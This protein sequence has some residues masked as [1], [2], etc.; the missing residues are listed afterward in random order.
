[1]RAIK[2]IRP[3]YAANAQ[4]RERF[5]REAEYLDQLRHPNI[6]R[7]DT[8][9]DEEGMLFMVMERLEGCAVD[10]FVGAPS[11]AM[12]CRIVYEAA[13]GLQKA[14]QAQ[15][16]HRDVKP[17][18]LVVTRDGGLRVLDFG[19]ARGTGS[20][21]LTLGPTTGGAY[22]PGTPAYYAPE[23]AAGKVATPQSDLYSL[24]VTLY[25]VLTG[26][27]PYEPEPGAEDS[28]VFSFMM[29]SHLQTPMPDV[30]R[31]RPEVPEGVQA[32]LQWATRKL[33]AER[34][35]DAQV[36]AERLK[37]FC[38][39]SVPLRLP[40]S[41]HP[42][43]WEPGMGAT[44]QTEP[45]VAFVSGVGATAMSLERMTAQE[46]APAPLAPVD[47]G[48]GLRLGLGLGLVG[49]LGAGV[50]AL[51]PEPPP[52]VAPSQLVATP[53]QHAP[54]ERPKPAPPE[55]P[56]PPAPPVVVVAQPEPKPKPEP[57]PEPK[58]DPKPEPE[59]VAEILRGFAF[60]PKR[61]GKAL[62]TEAS[63]VLPKVSLRVAGLDPVPLPSRTGE[64]SLGKV[65]VFTLKARYVHQAAGVHLELFS[66]PTGYVFLDKH[67]VGN[68]QAGY[69]L[70]LW[71]G[72][73]TQQVEL[74]EGMD[75]SVV[76]V[77]LS[78]VGR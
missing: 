36:F 7:V 55:P 43:R 71:V 70:N 74:H 27:L 59:P 44:R 24:G 9:G 3:E 12:A 78:L 50:V 61:P 46:E 30:R 26:R 21:Q 32:L 22:Q 10:R 16:T 29:F 75:A 25:E 39:L 63:E 35:P 54:V 68:T 53:I 34:I 62:D 5:L 13:L 49:L 23:L 4:F 66:S 47:A 33:P 18:N 65:G 38:D 17:A 67:Q 48:R 77:A 1:V 31:L 51:W 45:H 60:V 76:R 57:E 72:G 8:I 19:I 6:L 41:P 2:V 37:P 64:V 42:V 14:H 40:E 15:I 20:H 73:G 56:P 11:V 52:P 69:E 58:A 28:H